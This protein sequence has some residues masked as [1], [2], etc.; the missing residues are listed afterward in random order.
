MYSPPGSARSTTAD[1]VGYEVRSA[2]AHEVERRG[3]CERPV[4]DGPHSREHG[5][6]DAL[7]AVAVTGHAATQA[8][9]GVHD[10]ADLTLVVDL[11]AR[12][13]LRQPRP[14]RRARLDQV[15]AA[16]DVDLHEVAQRLRAA[17]AVRQRRQ[18]R[19]PG[20]GEDAVA[21][22]RGDEQARGQRARNHQAP[23][24]E[25]G[26]Q[27]DV[28]KERRRGRADRRRASGEGDARSGHGRRVDVRVEQPGQDE[29]TADVDDPPVTRST[30]VVGPHGGRARP[31]TPP[32]RRRSPGPSPGRATVLR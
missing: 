2:G 13:L 12:I 8:A 14:L 28:L 30:R 1:S 27:T 17:D 32:S 15:D 4:L 11:H 7:V 29:R 10:G 3:R 16:G 26:A 20:I 31:R 21:Q 23:E 25:Q 22:V 9:R 19:E 24:L 18:R 6:A 5:V